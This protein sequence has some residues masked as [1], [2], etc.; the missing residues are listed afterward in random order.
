MTAL[1]VIVQR[2]R[3]HLITDAATTC[4]ATGRVVLIETKVWAFPALKAA[5]ATSGAVVPGDIASF[6]DG[7]T[8]RTQGDLKAI[9]AALAHHMTARADQIRP[10]LKGNEANGAR[11]AAIAWNDRLKRP[12]AWSVGTYGLSGHGGADGVIY[13]GGP[14]WLAPAFEGEDYLSRWDD[15]DPATDGVEILEAQRRTVGPQGWHVVGGFG[16]LVTV[17]RKG[18]RWRTLVTWPQD[19]LGERITTDMRSIAA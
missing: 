6:L 11:V 2:D 13:T 12:E 17:T 19:K 16:E 9:I 5:F 8:A 1:N 15:L 3:A 7:R 18:L 14:G 10:L 4:T